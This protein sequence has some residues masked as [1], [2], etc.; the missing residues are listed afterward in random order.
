MTTYE[1]PG[2]RI[3][4]VEIDL[5]SEDVGYVW[6]RDPRTSAALQHW[7][8]LKVGIIIHWGIYAHIGQAGS[9]SL[10]REHLGDFTE[11][12][13]GWE[14]SPSEYHDWYGDRQRG[15]TGPDY[16]PAEW[17]AACKRAGAKYM[18]F[19]A[20][21]HDG[22]AMYD[23][24][25]SNFKSTSEESGL[26]RDVLRETFDAFR[27]ADLE[28][29]VYF[30]KADWNHPGYWD[31]A[32]PITDRFHNYSI[33]ESPRQWK[34]FVDYTHAQV[35]ELL[36]GYGT[37]N[38]LWLDAGWV[39]EPAEPIDMDALV[40]RAIGSQPDLLVVD[41][42]VHGPYEMYR[43]PEQVIPA[44]VIS[45]PWESCIPLTEHWCSTEVDERARPLPDILRELATVVTRGGNYLIGIGP[46]ATGRLSR[47]VDQRLTE[48]GEWLDANGDA[49]YESRPTEIQLSGSALEWAATTRDGVVYAF[50]IAATGT[51]T[52]ELEL[53]VPDGFASAHTPGGTSLEL[54][55]T[56]AG[57]VVRVPASDAPVV[58]VALS[59]G[60]SDGPVG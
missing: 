50:G 54:R 18:I 56:A 10:H 11:P 13:A 29:G 39:R 8:D 20:K 45:D 47:S 23:T 24:R 7:Q 49:V 15:F 9:W 33:E 19:T 6:P 59:P 36:T 27:A 14:G 25:F 3:E 55:P 43:T 26:R 41:R 58:I 51:V 16:D 2:P 12:P 42:T 32:R 22:F 28:V 34:S 40:A 31:R 38:V 5:A 44:D 35:E 4:G 17:A 30:S 57:T 46:D 21:H 48:L 60:E 1:T 52:P 53:L 37:V